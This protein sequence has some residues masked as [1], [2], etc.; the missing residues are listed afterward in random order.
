[1][2][3]LTWKEH[4]FIIR[5]FKTYYKGLTLFFFFQL[6][7]FKDSHKRRNIY[8]RNKGGNIYLRNNLQVSMVYYRNNQCE[9]PHLFWYYFDSAIKH[10]CLQWT[11]ILFYNV[12]C[13]VM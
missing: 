8:L 10:C 4:S 7:L 9:I 13:D 6:Q 12:C 11:T 1:M 3:T 2:I 5:I